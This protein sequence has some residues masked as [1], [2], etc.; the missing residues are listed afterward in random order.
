MS[1][2]TSTCNQ[3][4]KISNE[5]CSILF[6]HRKSSTSEVYLSLTFEFGPAVFQGL[7]SHTG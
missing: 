6:S 1:I 4:F 2:V 7:N 5:L 3:C